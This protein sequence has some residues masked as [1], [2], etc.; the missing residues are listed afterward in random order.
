DLE[1]LKALLKLEKRVLRLAVVSAVLGH[2]EELVALA[3]GAD[4]LAHPHL[5]DSGVV[6]PGVIEECHTRVEGRVHQPD[7]LVLGRDT[8]VKSAETEQRNLLAGLS[9]GAERHAG[10][11]RRV[12]PDPPHLGTQGSDRADFSATTARVPVLPSSL[13]DR[14][15]PS[16]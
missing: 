1:A 8:D 10:G 15:S 11:I 16:W 2:D 6:L 9:E 13:P 5:R 7:R 4:R 14:T 12:H 3:P